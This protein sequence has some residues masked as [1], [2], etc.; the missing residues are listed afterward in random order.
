MRTYCGK[1]NMRKAEVKFNYLYL[2]SFLSLLIIT[3][4]YISYPPSN[5]PIL[6]SKVV[7]PSININKNE[8]LQCPPNNGIKLKL[9]TERK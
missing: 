8:V 4:P 6:Y 5:I 9:M 1:R 7:L 2:C 3:F